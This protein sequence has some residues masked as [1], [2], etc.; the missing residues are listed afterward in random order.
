[1]LFSSS[2]S[3]RLHGLGEW[4]EK[5]L[6]NSVGLEM[7]LTSAASHRSRR[8]SSFPGLTTSSP[9]TPRSAPTSLS[10]ST[11]RSAKLPA[12][13]AL[14]SATA[15]GSADTRTDSRVRIGGLEPSF[16]FK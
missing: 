7:S 15:S 8:A 10:M 9:S 11:S 3:A 4:H 12:V 14:G 5:C 16:R 13:L 6:L 2:G 1:M